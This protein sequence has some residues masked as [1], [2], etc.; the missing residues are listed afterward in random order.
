MVL[1]NTRRVKIVEWQTVDIIRLPTFLVWRE[2]LCVAIRPVV[3]CWRVV[4]F[5]DRTLYKV[6]FDR[7]T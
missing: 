3:V 5:D 2:C 1:K 6:V 7:Q 4:E